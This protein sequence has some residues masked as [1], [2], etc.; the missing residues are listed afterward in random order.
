MRSAAPL[1]SGRQVAIGIA[2]LMIGLGV[3]LG[4]LAAQDSTEN[5]FP[6]TPRSNPLPRAFMATWADPMFGGEGAGG[7]CGSLIDEYGNPRGTCQFPVDQLEPLLN[8]RARAWIE[9]FDEPISPRWACV[10][11][12]ITTLLGE[13]YLWDFSVR[14]DVVL[15]HFEQSNWVREIYVDGRPHPP[16]DEVFYH[17]HSI[18]R[19]DGST[20]VVES[21]NFMFD[22]D[23][24]DDQSHIA[25]SHLKTLTERYSVT[26]PN[27][28][29]VE[30]TVEDPVFLTGPFT[31]TNM[32][33]TP[34]RG[35]TGE[36]DCDPEVGLRH[37]YSTVPQRYPD[38][39]NFDQFSN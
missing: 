37:L 24:F 3:S 8:G 39:A 5:G 16:A 19:M 30:I 13:P 36:W 28:M 29:E 32:F 6:E 22:P 10:A 25:T 34:D 15:Q 20:F 33:A 35:Y 1:V 11:A 17:G 18:G 7:N 38:D 4:D 9:F 23:G 2:V 21:T 27:T 14:P 26:G 12:N 31:W